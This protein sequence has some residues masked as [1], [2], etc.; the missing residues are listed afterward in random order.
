[1]SMD[2]KVDVL[3]YFLNKGYR[4]LRYLYRTSTYKL[5]QKFARNRNH[6]DKRKELK[7]RKNEFGNG[8]SGFKLFFKF[9]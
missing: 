8:P 3:Q 6:E 5:D 4:Y 9:C 1:M 2:G 7:E